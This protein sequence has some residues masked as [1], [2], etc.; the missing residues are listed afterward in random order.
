VRIDK[1]L[2]THLETNILLCAIPRRQ[3][4]VQKAGILKEDESVQKGKR[5]GVTLAHVVKAEKVKII[6]GEMARPESGGL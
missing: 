6:W 1:R 4:F 5:G 2:A 3:R